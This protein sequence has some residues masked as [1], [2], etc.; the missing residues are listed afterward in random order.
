MDEKD[1]AINIVLLFVLK[2]YLP[3]TITTISMM[4][5]CKQTHLNIPCS[6]RFRDPMIPEKK[7]VESKLY[8]LFVKGI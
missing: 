6:L 3:I 1:S 7:V 2:H 4:F 8:S 5:K